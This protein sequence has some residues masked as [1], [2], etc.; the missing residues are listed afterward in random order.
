MALTVIFI[1]RS[2]DPASTSPP[3]PQPA[4]SRAE[5]P[6]DA[7]G[8]PAAGDTPVTTAITGAVP[9]PPPENAAPAPSET[10]AAPAPAPAAPAPTETP[11]DTAPPATSAA[12]A[13]ITPTSDGT[14]RV[15]GIEYPI[16][17]TCLT[18]PFAPDGGDYVVFSYLFADG[19]GVPQIVEQWFMDGGATGASYSDGGF[20]VGVDYAPLGA[21]QFSVS[22][23]RPGGPVEVVVNPAEAGPAECG[24][25]IAT[26][27]PTTP[28]FAYTRTV[29]DACFGAEAGPL[30]YV[31]YLSDGGKFTAT[32]NAGSGSTLRYAEP[33]VEMYVDPDAA[34]TGLPDGLEIRGTASS[35]GFAG[36]VTKDI[37]VTLRNDVIRTCTEHDTPL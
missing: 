25:T 18:Q 3:A 1:R 34:L 22:L 12:G 20:P 14:V 15:A 17:R 21:D 32:P 31:G 35:D 29:V 24:G 11:A 33:F 9:Q 8:Q 5:Q 19:T 4:E 23:R 28:D 7:T 27:D 36:A 26:S 37:V 30:Q 13:A 10:P 16:E 6:V 2:V